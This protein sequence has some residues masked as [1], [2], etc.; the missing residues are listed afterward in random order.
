MVG[1]TPNA[2][3]PDG[4][5]VSARR[6][7]AMAH[8]QPRRWRS[9]LIALG[10]GVLAA[11]A[12][13]PVH[14]LPLLI[15]AFV[16]LVWLLDR[17][18]SGWR[19]FG[20]GFWFGCGYHIAGLYWLAWPLTLDLAR[21]GWMIPFAVFGISGGLAIFTG[22]ATAAVHRT[23][24]RGLSRILYLAVAW[25]AAEWVRGHVLSGF[26]WNLL[27]NAWTVV[28]DMLQSAAA[29]GAYGLSALTVLIA[30]LPALWLARATGPRLAFGGPIAALVLL[31]LLWAGG[32]WRLAANPP[33]AVPGVRMRI[34]QGAIAQS[35][36]WD[37]AERLRNFQTYLALSGMK[38]TGADARPVTHLVW[39]E[40]ALDFRFQTAYAG[41][42]LTPG[43]IQALRAVIP[44]G[45]LLLTG[46]I[47]DNGRRSWNSIQAVTQDGRVAGTYDKHHLVPFGEYV[48]A[49]GIL[50]ALGVE[51]IA[52]GRGD[53]AAADAPRT[54]TLPGLPA[55]GPQICYEAIF[56][57]NVVAAPRPGW[58]LNVTNDAW[59]GHTSGPY[60][61]LAS[62]RLRAVEE[63][64]PLVRAANTGISAVIDAHGRT[65][66]RLGLGQRGV[67]DA[68]L[69]RAAPATLYARWG[70]W[71][72]LPLLLVLGVCGVIADRGR[73]A[74]P[75]L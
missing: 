27:A 61:H 37:P 4:N 65:V 55:V 11:A 32:A 74:K 45:G 57:G 75:N 23:R 51:K 21:F 18:T 49:R 31:A 7:A 5:A 73:N 53:Y 36:K 24:A 66:A 48:P 38:P 10:A 1:A 13:P 20:A 42:R 40:T 34:V 17:S 68:P 33:E 41:A 69:P 44:A 50:A 29:I 39:P 72:L 63:G 46:I 26:P 35:L 3:S 19:A 12:L 71:I 16:L 15:P 67:L 25:A 43:M 58:M 14:A 59:F 62:A 22:L 30:A 6:D 52:H 54:L 28:P 64:L 70:D 2:G 8:P 60:Q 9:R 56:P 47:R